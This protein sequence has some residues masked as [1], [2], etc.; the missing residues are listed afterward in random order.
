M[1]LDRDLPGVDLALCDRVK[2]QM[3]I[4]TNALDAAIAS[5]TNDH[6][7]RLRGETDRLMR[8]LARILIEIERSAPKH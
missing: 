7:E 3:P 1:E 6:L 8:A 4:V 2:E 5:P